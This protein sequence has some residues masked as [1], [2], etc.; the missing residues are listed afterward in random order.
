MRSFRISALENDLQGNGKGKEAAMKEREWIRQAS[1]SVRVQLTDGEAERL[2]LEMEGLLSAAKDSDA[3]AFEEA[4][5]RLAVEETALRADAVGE[6]LSAEELLAAA[7]VTL[8]GYFSVPRA[9]E[10]CHEK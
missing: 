3:P 10:D 7:A 6:S 8:N 9:L 4:L 2:A 1:Q 5:E